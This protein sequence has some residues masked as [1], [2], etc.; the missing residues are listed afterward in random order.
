MIRNAYGGS[1]IVVGAG[2]IGIA[3]AHYLNK[4]G[5]KV[6]VID[7]GTVASACSH[8][9]CGY[10][11]PSHVPPLTEPGAFAVALKSLF[12][13]QAA[14]R[15]KPRLSPA[16]WNW[17]WQFA[18]R[19]NHRQVLTAGKHLQ[20]I[21][22]ASMDE[23]QNLVQQESLD[24]EWKENGLLYVLQTQ[25]GMDAFA[26]NDKMLTEHFGV[27]A[28]RIEGD[29]LPEFEP[30]LKSGLA[31][32]FHYPKDTSVR[33]DRLNQ[34]WADRLR[35]NGV[36]FIEHCELTHVDKS[37]GHIS[38]LSTTHGE[39]Q[40][41]HY[42]F[43]M[44]AWSTRWSNELHCSIPIEPGKGYSVTMNRVENLPTHPILF[45]EHKVGVS[46]FETG[47]RL[48]SMMEF[49]GYDTSIRS[50]RINQLRDSARPYLVASVDG[51]AKE[52]WYGWRPMTWDSLPIIGAT[53]NLDNAFLATGHNMLGLSLAPS[54]GRLITELVTEQP[55]HIDA[56]PFSPT[57]F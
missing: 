42:V 15:V 12:N 40:A 49:A 57:R 43:A 32:A 6:T 9:N 21:L 45:P 3:C 4:A 55:P 26:K 50:Q 52:T 37:A 18:R 29:Q 44:G 17:M 36:Q 5:L 8:G 39:L 35:A 16:M 53:P 41:D 19:C 48:G 22:D 33:P 27:S 56:A 25:R 46:P 34:Q 1:V 54:T 38:H 14:F 2:T 51:E 23:Y 24:C 13:P 28:N 30:G 47:L 10:I 7:R 31:G 11:C 20:M